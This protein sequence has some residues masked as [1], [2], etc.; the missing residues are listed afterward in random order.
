MTW[1]S[2]DILI[3]VVA[4]VA[5]ILVLSGPSVLAWL[6]TAKFPSFSRPPAT[7]SLADAHTILEIA[8]RLKADGNAAGFDL[9]QQL[10]DVMMK[11]P[12]DRD[13]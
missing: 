3:R 10:I 4:F 5:A 7:S 12:V 6:R 9:C 11:P 1:L 2:G 13:A 8:A